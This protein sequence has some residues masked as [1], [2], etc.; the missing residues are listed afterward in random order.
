MRTP[1]ALF[2][3][4]LLALSAAPAS[5]DLFAL[6]LDGQGS[7]LR[8][9][10][11]GMPDSNATGTIAGL[12]AGFRG[13]LQ[14]LFL[15]LIVDYHHLF[16]GGAGADILHA[17]LGVGYRTDSIPVVDLYVQGS[18]G[19]LMLAADGSAFTTEASGKIGPEAGGQL[20]AGGG[21]D[22]PFAGDFLAIGI[23]ADVGGHYI[24]GEFG[25]DFSVNLHFGLRI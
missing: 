19:L 6:E 24:T 12:G 13:R 14:L 7:Y 17:G 4:L 20:R 23:G 15:N 11:I 5:A 1:I 10:K 3:A 25:Y 9:D 16:T 2:A 8:M 18:I 22:F 21:I